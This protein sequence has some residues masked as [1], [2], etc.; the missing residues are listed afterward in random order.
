MDWPQKRKR[1]ARSTSL[2]LRFDSDSCRNANYQ[3][4][5]NARPNFLVWQPENPPVIGSACLAADL[6][7]AELCPRVRAGRKDSGHFRGQEVRD[8]NPLRCGREQAA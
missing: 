4:I 3:R 6:N 8:A 5:D 7:A 1:G 2:L